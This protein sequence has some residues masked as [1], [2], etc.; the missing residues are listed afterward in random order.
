MV[1]FQES[2]QGPSCCVEIISH[3]C[4]LAQ[5]EAVVGDFATPEPPVP[6]GI[7]GLGA[8]AGTEI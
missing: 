3:E 7:S 5:R 4:T 8:S 2:G 1:E 6:D